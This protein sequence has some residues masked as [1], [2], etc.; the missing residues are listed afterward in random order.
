MTFSLRFKAKHNCK[1][2]RNLIELYCDQWKRK[3]IKKNDKT[4]SWKLENVKLRNI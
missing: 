4:I 3:R 1:F 2:E